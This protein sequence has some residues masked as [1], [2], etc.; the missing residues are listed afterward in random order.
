MEWKAGKDSSVA[1][2]NGGKIA[3]VVLRRNPGMTDAPVVIKNLKYWGAPRNTGFI[4]MSNQVEAYREG[5]KA[6][7]FKNGNGFM[8]TVDLASKD[9]K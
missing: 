9:F 4:L 5:D 8:I 1:R 6:F 2:L 7:E 3:E